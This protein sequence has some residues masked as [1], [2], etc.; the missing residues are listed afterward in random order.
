M[1]IWHFNLSRFLAQGCAAGA[2]AAAVLGVA[3]MLGGCA[4]Y[5]QNAPLYR[6]NVTLSNTNSHLKRQLARAKVEI[7]DLKS[8]LAHK[9]PRMATL[10]PKRLAE[11]FTVAA[12]RISSDTRAA[13]LKNSPTLNGFRVFIKTLMHGGMILPASGQFTIQAFD[14]ANGVKHPLVGR[15]IF[16]PSESKKY[17]YG[18]FGLDEFGFDCPWKKPPLH[19]LI[20]FRVKFVDALTGRTF[21]TQRALHVDIRGTGLRS[22]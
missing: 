11:L 20:T 6:Q 9:T 13:H 5:A 17:W 18:L 2:A 1:N 15:W 12:V 21:T 19:A 4:N 8:D 22:E 3:L 7:A 16:T 14:L 10:P